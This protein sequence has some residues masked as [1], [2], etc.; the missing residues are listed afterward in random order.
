[1]AKR[2]DFSEERYCRLLTFNCPAEVGLQVLSNQQFNA[3]N[4]RRLLYR[5]ILK[6]QFNPLSPLAPEF[7]SSELLHGAFAILLLLRPA[8]AT[9][10]QS[11]DAA[12]AKPAPSSPTGRERRLARRQCI[13]KLWARRELRD[14]RLKNGSFESP[15]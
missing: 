3:A 5:Q 11:S 10:V 15:T 4:Q 8:S 6:V 2:G 12:V 7:L 9:K 13:C 1:M 14:I